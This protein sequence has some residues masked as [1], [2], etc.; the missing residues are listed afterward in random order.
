MNLT[1]I[2]II[3]TSTLGGQNNIN[4]VTDS[5]SLNVN[6]FNFPDDFLWG[7]ATAAHQV[8]G[9]CVNNNWSNWETSPSS[10][11]YSFLHSKQPA[12]TACEHWIRY[13]EDIRLMKELGV[14]AYRFSV[15]WSK[16]EPEQGK[17]NQNALTHYS[18][19]IDSLIAQG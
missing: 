5:N 14:N 1:F 6:T 3:I 19:V 16:I 11:D 12:G 17:F 4:H 9:N 15:E 10:H 8:E 2:L 7:T 18:M 13:P